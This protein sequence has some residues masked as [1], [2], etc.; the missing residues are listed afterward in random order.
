VNLAVREGG[1]PL[2]RTLGTG[3]SVVEPTDQEL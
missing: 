2:R 3:W 1:S